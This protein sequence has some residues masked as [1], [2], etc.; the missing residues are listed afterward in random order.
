MIKA[1]SSDDAVDLGSDLLHVLARTKPE[2]AMSIVAPSRAARR[3]LTG[4]GRDGSA[5]RRRRFVSVHGVPCP[6]GSTCIRQSSPNMSR[7][8]EEHD[9][10]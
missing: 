4:D 9:T 10:D 7:M 2:D 8:T 1:S 6:V 3:R 5:V